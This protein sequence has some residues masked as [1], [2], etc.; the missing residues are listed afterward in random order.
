MGVFQE[1]KKKKRDLWHEWAMKLNPSSKLFL[2]PLSIQCL[3]GALRNVKVDRQ[4]R[5]LGGGE[6]LGT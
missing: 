4:E 3:T 2:T 6:A 1:K 5:R